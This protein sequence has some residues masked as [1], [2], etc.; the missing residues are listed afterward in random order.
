MPNVYLAEADG[1]DG[2]VYSMDGKWFFEYS[3]DG[4][5]VIE[6]LNIKF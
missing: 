1:K 6:E 2:L 4:N 3:K 5:L